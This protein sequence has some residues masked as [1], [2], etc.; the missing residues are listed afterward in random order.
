MYIHSLKNYSIVSEQ[1]SHHT[2]Y[3]MYGKNHYNIV[4]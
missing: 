4:K 1:K 2:D 3:F